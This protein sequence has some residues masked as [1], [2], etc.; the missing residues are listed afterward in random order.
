MVDP[1]TFNNYHLPINSMK[2]AILGTLG[3]MR[4]SRLWQMYI[5]VVPQM[6]GVRDESCLVAIED[7]WMKMFPNDQ[8][9]WVGLV[10]NILWRTRHR[11]LE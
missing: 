7:E 4:G 6:N 3:S 5:D 2:H 10:L 9:D 11:K 1:F 8:R